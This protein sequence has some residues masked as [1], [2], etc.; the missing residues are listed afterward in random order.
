MIYIK[1]WYISLIYHSYL[2]STRLQHSQGA[3]GLGELRA[4]GPVNGAANINATVGNLYILQG[5]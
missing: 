4:R 3:V 5:Q 2:A 1:L